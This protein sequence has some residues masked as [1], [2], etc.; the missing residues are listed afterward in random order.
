VQHDGG[1]WR[2]HVA[3]PIALTLARN[4]STGRPAQIDRPAE[5]DGA[6][7]VTNSGIC[8]GFECMGCMRPAAGNAAAPEP[9]PDSITYPNLALA[10]DDF[11]HKYSKVIKWLKN[12]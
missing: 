4:F 2:C 3:H 11:A 9:F 1:D 6:R 5:S 7:G 10:E 8:S 12:C